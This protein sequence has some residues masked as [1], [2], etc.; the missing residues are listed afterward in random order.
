MYTCMDPSLN[1][2]K[3]THL[4]LPLDLQV[5]T[6]EISGEERFIRF[7]KAL[8]VV[9]CKHLLSKKAPRHFV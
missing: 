7:D 9:P 8:E 5:S 4:Q 6:L 2:C 1:V 3:Y